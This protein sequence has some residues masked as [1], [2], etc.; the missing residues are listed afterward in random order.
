MTG[1]RPILALR[2]AGKKPVIV[3]VSDFAWAL[4]DGLTVSVAC[5]TPELLD[6]RFLRGTTAVVTAASPERADRIGTACAAFARRV[7][8]NVFDGRDVVRV[9]DTDGVMAWPR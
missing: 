4:L 7:I 6:L 3:W 1:E 5:D 2:R 8:T 9:T